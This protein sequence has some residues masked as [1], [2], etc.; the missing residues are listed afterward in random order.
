M[1]ISIFLLSKKNR[2]IRGNTVVRMSISNW[3]NILVMGQMNYKWK[4]V[5]PANYCWDSANNLHLPSK[6]WLLRI[7]IHNLG[8][9]RGL[10][11]FP[12][13]AIFLVMAATAYLKKTRENV[14]F[15]FEKQTEILCKYEKNKEK[16]LFIIL[17]FQIQNSHIWKG[18]FFPYKF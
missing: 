13:S 8:H 2:T 14:S 9:I 18:K 10:I 4:L 1:K 15:N 5:P 3:W 11:P 16:R 12:I 7:K 6:L 17:D